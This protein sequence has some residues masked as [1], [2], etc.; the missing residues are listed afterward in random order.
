M[1]TRTMFRKS[2]LI[3]PAEA[4]LRNAATKDELEDCWFDFCDSFADESPE[5]SHLLEV[6]MDMLARF[7]AEHVVKL[8]RT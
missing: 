2:A 8:L 5:R 7:K 1:N 6:Y 4:A 3:A